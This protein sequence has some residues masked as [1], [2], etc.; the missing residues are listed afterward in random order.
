MQLRWPKGEDGGAVLGGSI[1][2]VALEAIAGI[3]LREPDQ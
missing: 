3:T 2:S 1:A